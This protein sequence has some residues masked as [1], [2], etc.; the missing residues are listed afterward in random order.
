MVNGVWR[1]ASEY[2]SRTIG[3]ALGYLLSGIGIAAATAV[4]S[5]ATSNPTILHGS[6]GALAALAFVCLGVL[7]LRIFPRH[8]ETQPTTGSNTVQW[9]I[10]EVGWQT[11]LTAINLLGAM[12]H[13][14]SEGRI[15][16][17]F[18]AT[19]K[20]KEPAQT[21]AQIFEHYRWNIEPN[22][23]T[24]DYT[25]PAPTNFQGLRVKYRPS[26]PPLYCYSH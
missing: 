26:I 7:I 10:P 19:D 14:N 2:I 18:L 5:R 9:V 15:K 4:W 8:K 25:F 23:E 20:G 22:T 1:Y 13:L 16:L 11:A 12:S 3:V 6:I 24:G 17:K 21:V